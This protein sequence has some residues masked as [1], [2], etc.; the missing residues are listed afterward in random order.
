MLK[1]INYSQVFADATV[2]VLT[3]FM[4]A[5]RTEARQEIC[6]AQN[7]PEVTVLLGILGSIQGRL[8]IGMTHECALKMCEAMNFGEPFEELDEL[9]LATLCELANLAA[10]R[11]VSALNDG[12]S[13]LSITPPTVICGKDMQASGN[14]LSTSMI[15]V[16]TSVGRLGV[17]VSSTDSR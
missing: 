6:G 17:S 8:A 9:A 2:D 3:T 12:G 16:I 14:Q 10:G 1:T 7:L 11:A 4:E 13:N 5:P 15:P